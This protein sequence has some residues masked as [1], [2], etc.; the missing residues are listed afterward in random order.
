LPLLSWFR[1]WRIVL[2]LP[3]ATQKRERW[4]HCETLFWQFMTR[5]QN[6]QP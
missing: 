5:F 6:R 3:S 4:R 2:A 1:H